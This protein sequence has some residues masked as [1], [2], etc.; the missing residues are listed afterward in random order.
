[1]FT[2]ADQLLTKTNSDI[3]IL[4][5]LVNQTLTQLDSK[6]IKHLQTGPAVRN[7]KKTINKHIELIEDKDL[8][9][10]YK[11]ISDHIIKTYA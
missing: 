4:L 7:E 3:S 2:I 1:M 8:K 11:K 5:P 9:I 6:N 10:I